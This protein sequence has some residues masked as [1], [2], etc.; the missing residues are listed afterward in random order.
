[1]LLRVSM[2][3]EFILTLLVCLW[4]RRKTLAWY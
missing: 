2:Q 4:R 3:T 1:M